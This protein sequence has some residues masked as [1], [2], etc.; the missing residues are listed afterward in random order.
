MESTDVKVINFDF[1]VTVKGQR[2]N[3]VTARF[4]TVRDAIEVSKLGLDE[5][6]VEAALAA[7]LMGVELDEYMSWPLAAFPVI[8]RWLGPLAGLG[9]EKSSG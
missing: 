3:S 5:H 4:P 8:R 6:E 7:R 9:P 2:T 1:E